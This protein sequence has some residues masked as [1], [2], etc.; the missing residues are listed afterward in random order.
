[1]LQV[2]REGVFN[3]THFRYPLVYG[4]NNICPAEWSLVKRFLDGRRSLILPGGGLTLVSRGYAEN[5]AHGI[6]LAVDKPE[7]SA[8][9]VYNIC[10]NQLLY[11]HEWVSQVSRV[12]GHTFETVE[13]P[14]CWLPAG[15][16]A[17]STQ[18]LYRHHGV[19]SLEKIKSQLGYQDIVSAEEA[20][21]RTV[22]WYHDHPLETGHEAERN[23]GDPF[24]YAYEDAVIAAY[25]KASTEFVEMEKGLERKPV[26]WKHPYQ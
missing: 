16:R 5:V 1:M 9:E 26:I 15:F 23:L 11:N 6:L 2:H 10:D 14:F 20:I 24:D 12:L 4:P 19:M 18:L 8:G 13:I 17:T 7:A 25:R 21:E 3:V 22:K